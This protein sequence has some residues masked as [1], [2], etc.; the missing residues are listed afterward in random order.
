[1]NLS[2][3]QRVKRRI[4]LTFASHYYHPDGTLELDIDEKAG[5]DPTR[6]REETQDAKLNAWGKR[7]AARSQWWSGFMVGALVAGTLVYWWRG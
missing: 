6:D 5:I 1:M 2:F 4:W 7:E 3:G